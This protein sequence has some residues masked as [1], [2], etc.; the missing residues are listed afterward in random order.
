MA[1]E[2]IKEYAFYSRPPRPT[3]ET[4]NI[5][6]TPIVSDQDRRDWKSPRFSVAMRGI[7]DLIKAIDERLHTQEELC[8]LVSSY[9]IS[10]TPTDQ[11]AKNGQ[12]TEQTSQIFSPSTQ[13]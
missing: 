13:T 8:L 2:Q 4:V 7:E 10:I 5:V 12:E 6:N 9:K 3:R 11:L 1:L